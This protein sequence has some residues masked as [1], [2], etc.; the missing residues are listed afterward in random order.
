MMKT[1]FK[2]FITC[3]NCTIIFYSAFQ[4][5]Q[6]EADLMSALPVTLI[7]ASSLCLL[8][9]ALYLSYMLIITYQRIKKKT[10]GT[11]YFDTRTIKKDIAPIHAQGTNPGG[12]T[13][14]MD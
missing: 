12:H 5:I 14:K 1:F 6:N 10:A 7:T 9:N 2:I 8:I 3:F 13:I 11:N 4:F